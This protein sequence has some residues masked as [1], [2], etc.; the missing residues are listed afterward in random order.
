MRKKSILLRLLPWLIVLVLVAGAWFVLDKIY[1]SPGHS[2]ARDTRIISYDGDGK[3]LTMENDKLLFEMDGE[4]TQFKVTNK[5]TG[6][7]WYSNPEG[8]ENDTTATGKTVKE[9][10]SCTLNVHYYNDISETEV[11][12]YTKSIINQT[13]EIQQE[14]DGAIRVNY[15]LGEKVFMVPNAITKVDL[16]ALLANLKKKDQ[17]KLKNHF[18]L[19]ETKKLDKQKKKDELIALYPSVQEQ[20]LYSYS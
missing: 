2:F 19:V 5:E 17:G 14:D 15:S 6:K 13:F 12:N 10:L 1:S 3:P 4:T 8:R 11:N 9:Y 18:S 16:D 20:D 7:I